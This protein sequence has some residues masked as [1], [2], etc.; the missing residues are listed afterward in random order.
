MI[1]IQFSNL[2][3]FLSGW[4]VGWIVLGISYLAA[5]NV[6]FRRNLKKL[7]EKQNESDNF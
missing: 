6:A 2:V 3:C 1:H 4:L 5:Q 7:Q